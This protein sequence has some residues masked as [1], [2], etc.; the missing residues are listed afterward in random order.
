[1]RCDSSLMIPFKYAVIPHFL[2][3]GRLDFAMVFVF[4]W[5]Q[6]L[7]LLVFDLEFLS[8]FFPRLFLFIYRVA[9]TR[10]RPRRPPLRVRALQRTGASIKEKAVHYI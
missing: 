1:M 10:F 6:G 2:D 3:L 9:A 5:N 7:C 8:L 4:I